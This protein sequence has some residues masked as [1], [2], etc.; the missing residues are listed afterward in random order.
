MSS[1][2]NKHMAKETTILIAGDLCF[3]DRTANANLD[4]LIQSHIECI[5]FIKGADYSIVNLECAVVTSIFPSPIKKTGPNLKCS[6]KIVDFIKSMGFHACSLA[7]NHFADY[8]DKG[9]KESI[10]LLKNNSIDYVGAGLNIQE[11]RK[12]LYKEINNKKFAFINACEHEFTIATD[13]KPGCNPLNP[14]SLSYDI[15]EAKL[16]ADYVILIIHGGHEDY[17]LPSPRM[18]ETYRF[19]IDMGADVV[20]NHHQHCYSGYEIYNEKPIIYGLGNFSFD[21]SGVRGQMWNEGYMVI[22]HLGDII[23]FEYIPYIQNDE[24]IGIQ[25]QSDR[26]RFDEHMLQLN[27]TI[28]S[29]LQLQ[30]SWNMMVEKCR[31][32]YMHPLEP[33]QYSLFKKIA[34]YK[35]LPNKLIAKMLPEYMTEGR[36]L[37]LKNYFQCD[38]HRDIMNKLLQ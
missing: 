29:P 22:L 27:K 18:Q 36:K 12:I 34:K 32:E 31:S 23:T 19:F 6:N 38:S 1:I 35:L 24:Q 8:G 21:E 4:L 37:F 28:A 25:I 5:P 11:A 33:Y 20:V 9:V 26:C 30:E 10:A 2:A 13:T 17:Q 15:R 14:I 7:N 16:K 3:Q